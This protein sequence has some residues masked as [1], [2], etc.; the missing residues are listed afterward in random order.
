MWL[1][2]LGLIREVRCCHDQTGE[3]AARRRIRRV[4][5]ARRH[6]REARQDPDFIGADIL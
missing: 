4:V 1:P 6:F 3:K 5:A 2:C